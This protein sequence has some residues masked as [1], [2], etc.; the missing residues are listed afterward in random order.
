MQLAF[1]LLRAAER[2]P[3]ER[4]VAAYGDIASP[5]E[6]VVAAYGDIAS[7]ADDG[8]A[9]TRRTPLLADASARGDP[10]GFRLGQDPLFIALVPAPVPGGE[11]DDAARFS[12]ASFAM[13]QAVPAHAAHLL[14]TCIAAEPSLGDRVAF[15]RAVAAVARAAD[16]VGVYWGHG[17]VTHPTAFFVD[18]AR[19]ADVPIP[20][21]SGFSVAGDGPGRVSFLSLGMRQLDLPEVLVTTPQAT[22]NDA[23]FFLLDLL[24]YVATRGEPLPDGDTVGRTAEEKLRVE[25]VKSP[26]DPED[27]VCRIAM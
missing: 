2:P 24:A 6:R 10:L 27:E 13:R 11:A 7:P 18:T 1:V 9:S 16:A 4:V 21:W 5:A 15:T 20:L 12:L 22:A 23:L 14:V 17:H 25:Y 26:I 19:T 3:A 8:A